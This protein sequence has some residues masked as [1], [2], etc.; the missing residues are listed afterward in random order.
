MVARQGKRT[1]A[2]DV[3]AIRRELADAARLLSGSTV[4]QDRLGLY[5]QQ[6]YTSVLRKFPPYVHTNWNL[7]TTPTLIVRVIIT[8]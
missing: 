2:D 4:V 6:Y 7:L 3:V 5:I 1:L 8:M